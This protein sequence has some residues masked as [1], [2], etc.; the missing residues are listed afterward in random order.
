M[1]D[2]AQLC[3]ALLD[4]E[5]PKS[6]ELLPPRIGG[7]NAELGGVPT[8]RQRT[9]EEATRE[10]EPGGVEGL[11]LSETFTREPAGTQCVELAHLVLVV[12]DGGRGRD[13]LR[14]EPRASP[15]QVGKE[16]LVVGIQ[17]AELLGQEV[18]LV[19][20]DQCGTRVIGGDRI[21]G[22]GWS[23]QNVRAMHRGAGAGTVSGEGDIAMLGAP[24]AGPWV[25]WEKWGWKAM[26]A[27]LS[28]VPTTTAGRV[29]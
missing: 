21:P 3:D 12:G 15:A 2:Q 9:D 23:Q 19:L 29:R 28:T 26:V 25:K 20:D 27:S 14:C 17:R 7:G 4:R 10:V 6:I 22:V 1:G 13:D 24:K 5:A 8:G 11:S 18:E 16:G